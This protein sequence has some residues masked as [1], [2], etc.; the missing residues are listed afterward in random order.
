MMPK[1]LIHLHFVTEPKFVLVLVC[2]QSKCNPPDSVL[3]KNL[4]SLWAVGS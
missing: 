2:E 1:D 4:Y 3:P